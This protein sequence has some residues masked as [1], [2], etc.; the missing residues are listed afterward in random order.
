M[1]LKDFP[2]CR[3]VHKLEA[4]LDAW[5][6]CLEEF[7]TELYAAPGMLT[8]MAIDLLPEDLENELI[9]QPELNSHTKV[10]AWVKR[11]L[12][13]KRQKKMADFA[14]KDGGRV[15]AVTGADIDDDHTLDVPPPPSPHEAPRNLVKAVNKLTQMEAAL[16]GRG[17]QRGRDANRPTG[18]RSPRLRS[19]NVKAGFPW[20]PENCWHCAGK[21]RREIC[22]E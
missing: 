17:D 1:R 12:V 6:I 15:N 4:H 21:H 2:K 9:D 16:N 8:T 5:A 3:D 22:K 10:I 11:R 14:R 18:S 19:P 13:Y 7:A 20:D